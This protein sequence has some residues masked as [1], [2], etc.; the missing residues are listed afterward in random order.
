MINNNVNLLM[1]PKVWCEYGLVAS[2]QVSSVLT[3]LEVTP[4]PQWMTAFGSMIERAV[5]WDQMDA[6]E[7]R[8][9]YE[10]ILCNH[11][12]LGKSRVLTEFSEIGRNN[13]SM[14]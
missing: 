11:H 4:R 5:S 12:G 2:T 6:Q 7:E 9:S 8:N 3:K 14:T 10:E 13:G 1:T